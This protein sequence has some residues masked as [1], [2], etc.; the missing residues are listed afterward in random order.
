MAY[1][2]NFLQGTTS[3]STVALGW[4][5]ADSGKPNGATAIG[6]GNIDTTSG[7]VNNDL[8]IATVADDFGAA[9]GSKVVA[10]YGD[11]DGSTSDRAGVDVA[12]AH[13]A[14]GTFAFNPSPTGTR[15]ET[16][17]I[18]GV[19]TKINDVADTAIQGGT[20]FKD[21]YYD[22]THGTI[23]DRKLGVYDINVLATPSTAI[24]PERTVTGSPGTAN[25]YQNTTDTSDAV[26]GEIFPTSDVPGE[27]TYHFGGLGKP[28]TD[29]YK[30]KDDLETE[31]GSSS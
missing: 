3:T 23:A 15:S 13:A 26:T 18:Q 24:H 17:I 4:T 28:T 30:A 10:N 2:D 25:T 6:V 19:T 12:K 8:A 1:G 7:P 11:R 21:G 5:L 22:N 16:F 29:E 14:S 27:L 31:T 9:I 20:R